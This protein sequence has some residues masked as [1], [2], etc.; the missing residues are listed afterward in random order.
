MS[1]ILRFGLLG[2]VLAVPFALPS[3]SEAAAPACVY[4]GRPVY[5]RSC[6]PYV[7]GWYRYHG[8]GHAHHHAHYRHHR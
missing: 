7:Y 1:R 8:Y 5:T 6:R 2:L 4:P 3:A